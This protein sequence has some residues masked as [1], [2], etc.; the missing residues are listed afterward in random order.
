MYHVHPHSTL[1]I[2]KQHPYHIRMY[3][4]I[5]KAYMHACTIHYIQQSF[6]LNSMHTQKITA[7]VKGIELQN[8]ED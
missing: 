4:Y 5:F 6:K 1:A 3:V 2:Y 8:M 7:R